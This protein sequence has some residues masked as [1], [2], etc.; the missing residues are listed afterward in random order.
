M[1]ADLTGIVHLFFS[2]FLSGTEGGKRKRESE[3]PNCIFDPPPL[4]PSPGTLQLLYDPPIVSIFPALLFHG[5]L[6][7][8]PPLSLGQF[9]PANCV[10]VDEAPSCLLCTLT[11]A[12]DMYI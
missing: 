4:V 8:P 9:T 11:G 1:A 7:S 5:E 12:H 3:D 6:L 10:I 2:F